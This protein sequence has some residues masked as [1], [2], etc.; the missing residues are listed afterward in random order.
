MYYILSIKILQGSDTASGNVLEKGVLKYGF[1]SY[2]NI[3]KR[4][5]K[6]SFL[7]LSFLK[8]IFQGF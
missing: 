2:I 5:F 6:N 8:V 7:K 4:V 3:L 1:K